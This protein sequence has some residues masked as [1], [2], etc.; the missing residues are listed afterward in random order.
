MPINIA[1]IGC[2]I[3]GKNIARNAFE[4]GV[5][6]AVCDS[7]QQRSKSFSDLFSCPAL[8]FEQILNNSTIAGVIIA[9]NANSHQKLACDVL[10][11]GKH[12]YVEKPLTLSV[13]SALLIKKAAIKVQ[14]QVMVGHLL[15]Y[16]PA[17]TELKNLVK[18]GL[19]GKLQH[20]QANR[21]AMGRILKSESALFDLCPHDISM[22]LGLVKQMPLSIKCQSASHITNSGGDILSSSF[23]FSKG[24]TAMMHTSWYS[25]YKEHRLVVTGN[26]GS[27]VFDD[28][29]PLQKKLSLYKDK[30][31]DLGE[32][33]RIDRVD[34]VFLPV[35]DSEP[36]KNEISAF[37]QVCETGKPAITDIEE[38]LKV[39]QILS[40]MNLQIHGEKL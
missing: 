32:I 33:I 40:E 38:A 28:T 21:L 3:W 24:V 37:I 7:N 29:K 23:N 15:Q 8:S 36:L 26:S 14:K 5:L 1:I 13:R 2:G 9:T 35:C 25:P 39:Q 20:I 16:H 4:L 6:A 30:L 27:I 12:V 34:P 22:I 31:T 18:N 11:A 17:Y 19:I 10:N